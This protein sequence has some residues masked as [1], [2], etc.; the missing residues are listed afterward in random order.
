ML[1]D[2]NCLESWEFVLNPPAPRSGMSGRVNPSHSLFVLQVQQEST[3]ELLQPL[4]KLLTNG[5]FFFRQKVP[6]RTQSPAEHWDFS[7]WGQKNPLVGKG[8]KMKS[9]RKKKK[10]EKGGEFLLLLYLHGK[11]PV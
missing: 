2:L 6:S 5:I 4:R 3:K 8:R 10:E 7:S 1:G 11:I 9:G